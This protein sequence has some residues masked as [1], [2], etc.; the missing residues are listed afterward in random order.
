MPLSDPLDLV[1]DNQKKQLVEYDA[2]LRE[3]NQQVN[4]V[5]RAT[6]EESW[7]RHVRHCLALTA[8]RFPK[9]ASV[10]DYGSG[11]GLPGLVL[12][13]AF[14]DT[15]FYLVDA[16]LKKVRAV[17][18]MARRLG[19]D[20]VEA[21]HARAEKWKGPEGGAAYAVSR[22]TAPLW[23][24]WRWFEP[25]RTAAEPLDGCWAPGL[26]TLKGGDL[27]EEVAELKARRPQLRVRSTPVGELLPRWDDPTK[28][29]LSIY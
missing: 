18:D 12:A 20:N 4:L 8:K 2:L 27:R 7:D 23:T 3:H 17:D 24:L 5:S 10:V 19:L 26:L 6:A 22:A 16:V 25:V 13:I 15:R 1:S 28:V 21:H 11:G 29:L 14:P 9:G